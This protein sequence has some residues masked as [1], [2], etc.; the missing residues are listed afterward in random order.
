[1]DIK[2]LANQIFTKP[3]Q[4]ENSINIEFECIQNTATL[5]EALLELF[6]EGMKIKHGD[7]DNNK[8]DLLSL[9]QNDFLEMK[10][11]FKSFKIDLFYHVFHLQQL[12]EL[13]RNSYYIENRLKIDDI[14]ELFPEKPTNEL[15]KNYKIINSQVLKD[16][17]FQLQ[18][19]DILYII[20]FSL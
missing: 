14:N 12:E 11:Y 1:M 8:V 2:Q 13:T 10:K 20:Y 18:V 17:K 19:K 3:I 9:T 6:T 4:G 5:F 7:S 16:Y 15:L